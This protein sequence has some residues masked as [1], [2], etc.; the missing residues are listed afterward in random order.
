MLRFAQIML[1]LK[2]KGTFC[3]CKVYQKMEVI[4]KLPVMQS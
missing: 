3:F 1:P 4:T 2:K